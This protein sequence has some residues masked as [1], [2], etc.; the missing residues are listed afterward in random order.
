MKRLPFIILIFL[1]TAK[2]SAIILPD[3]TDAVVKDIKQDGNKIAYVCLKEPTKILTP[4]GKVV[5]RDYVYYNK[6]GRV[7]KFTPNEPGIASTPIGDLPY[8]AKEMTFYTSGN[9]N[10][11]YINTNLELSTPY[12]KITIAANQIKFYD[13]WIPQYIYTSDAQTFQI[14]GGELLL[15]KET[16]LYFYENGK[17]ERLRYKTAGEIE[18]PIGK[19]TPVADSELLFHENGA[20]KSVFPSEITQITVESN[21]FFVDAEKEIRFTDKGNIAGFS[22][23]SVKEISI[24][25]IKITHTGNSDESFLVFPNVDG[26]YVVTSKDELRADIKTDN[27]HNYGKIIYVSA[28][29]K[30]IAYLEEY[31]LYTFTTVQSKTKYDQYFNIYGNFPEY[32][33]YDFYINQMFAFDR[34]MKIIKYCNYRLLYNDD[35]STEKIYEFIDF[36]K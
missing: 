28:N 5:A 18:T 11:F 36:Q 10:T 7:Q 30:F 8:Q 19:L 14:S 35:D 16:K 34:D 26:S 2:L 9:I 17:I 29:K 22:T 6:N 25:T 1:F 12:G 21:T 20:L 33:D 27:Y 23:S 13:N 32:N 31:N 3:G 4:I 15:E 24:G